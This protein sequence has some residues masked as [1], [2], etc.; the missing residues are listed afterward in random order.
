MVGRSLEGQYRRPRAESGEV[1]LAAAGLRPDGFAAPLDL[2]L[3]AGEVVGVAGLLG[4][5]RTE[6]LEAIFGLRKREGEVAVVGN[7][8]R[9][10]DPRESIRHGVAFVPED[11]RRL[12]LSLRQSVLSNAG[13][14]DLGSRSLASFLGRDQQRRILTHIREE[15]SL[16]APDDGAPIWTLSGGNQQKLVLGRWLQRRPRLLLLDDP[17]RAIDVLTKREVYDVIHAMAEAGAAVLIV[18]SELPELLGLCDRILVLRE[19]QLA[20]TLGDG[21]GEEEVAAAMA[22][23]VFSP[24]GAGT[25]AGA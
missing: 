10:A 21:I 11:R 12:G 1:V 15:L 14:V 20:A 18:S 16:K 9:A 2:E 5:G 8:L 6:L 23:V 24:A 22:G 25:G 13:L 19:R 17:T 7:S 3:R 4:S